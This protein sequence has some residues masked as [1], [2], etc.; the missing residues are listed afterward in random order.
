M[1]SEGFQSGLCLWKSAAVPA[2]EA[3]GGLGAGQEATGMGLGVLSSS[4][5]QSCGIKS[6]P[7]LSGP[8]GWVLGAVGRRFQHWIAEVSLGACPSQ[9]S[10]LSPANPAG[11]LT[12]SLIYGGLNPKSTMSP[13]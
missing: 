11:I 6:G 4:S 7:E 9:S 5:G 13:F 1:Q 3:A 2:V 8:V 10:L 12:G